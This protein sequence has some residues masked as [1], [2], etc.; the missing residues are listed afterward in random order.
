LKRL[1]S[2]VRPYTFPLGRRRYLV[3]F[4]AIA[5]V[6]SLQARIAWITYLPLRAQLAA[7]SLYH[8]WWTT[9]YLNQFFPAHI[10]NVWTISA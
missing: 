10:H 2:Y 1:F 4:V 7:P 5:M 6:S 9:I 8:T 3:A